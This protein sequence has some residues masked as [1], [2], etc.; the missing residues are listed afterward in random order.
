M[1][2]VKNDMNEINLNLNSIIENANKQVII[3]QE[4]SNNS[5]FSG[6]I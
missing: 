3:Q 6:E 4:K 5:L 2:I 1:N